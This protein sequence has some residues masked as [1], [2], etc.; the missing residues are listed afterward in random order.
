VRRFVPAQ[1]YPS[2]YLTNGVV[3][4]EEAQI[5]NSQRPVARGKLTVRQAASVAGGL[6]VLSF[7]GSFAVG[8]LM[9]WSVVMA[10]ALGWLYSSPPLYLKR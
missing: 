10:L 6:A 5:N 3:V 4:A 2:I 9:V 7:V 1:R 8:S